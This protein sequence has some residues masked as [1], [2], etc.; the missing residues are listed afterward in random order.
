MSPLSLFICLLF[1]VSWILTGWV[2]RLALVRRI[3]DKPNGRSSHTVPTPRGGG[4]GVALVVVAGFLMLGALGEIAPRFLV[5]LVGGG[6][7]VAGAGWV[8]DVRGLSAPWRLVA[9]F[10]AALWFLTWIHGLPLVRIGNTTL[11][12]GWWGWVW[13]SL[14]I[15]WTINLY[16]FMDGIDGLAGSEAVFVSLAAGLIIAA[17]GD[18]GF[19]HAVLL[20][21]AGAGG[22]LVWNWA[23]ARLFLGDVG[24]GFL[25]FVFAAFAIRSEAKGSLPLV[26]W[27]ILLGIFVFDATI[28]LLRRMA[29]REKW[30][31]AHRKHAFQRMLARGWSHSRVTKTVLVINCALMSLVWWGMAVPERRMGGV[32]VAALGLLTALYGWVEWLEPM[33]RDR[34]PVAAE[35]VAIPVRPITAPILSPVPISTPVAARPVEVVSHPEPA[36]APAA[37]HREPISAVSA[38]TS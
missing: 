11:A 13:G 36:R 9:H 16:N 6:L 29:W 14:G 32:L 38:G 10:V 22:F 34:E 12:L 28:T 30:L 18:L 31:H 7:I 17:R 26:A 35:P 8:D 4:F 21:A 5:G 20:V 27:Y 24:S 37:S 1:V 2:R 25:G 33:R 19:S 15:V 3:I 23:P